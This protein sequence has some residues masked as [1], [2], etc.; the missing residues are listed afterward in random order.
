M[1]LRAGTGADQRH[2]DGVGHQPFGDRAADARQMLIAP[3]FDRR[4]QALADGRDDVE[5]VDLARLYTGE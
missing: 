5:M 2:L 1:W 3:A 4:L